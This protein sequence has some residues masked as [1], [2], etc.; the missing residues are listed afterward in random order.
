M[1]R[2]QTQQKEVKTQLRELEEE[3]EE[4]QLHAPTQENLDAIK[5]QRDLSAT[6][7]L[8]HKASV[9]REKAKVECEQVMMPLST[10]RSAVSL[11]GTCTLKR[12][13]ANTQ[14]L[15]NNFSVCL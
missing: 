4:L 15:I 6:K 1:T 13:N 14:E 2:L 7:A 9:D 11:M 8:L 3:E 5:L 10:P 12:S